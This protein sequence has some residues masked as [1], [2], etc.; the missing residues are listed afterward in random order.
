MGIRRKRGISSSCTCKGRLNWALR[1]CHLPLPSF[2]QLWPP[3]SFPQ[4]DEDE[5]FSLLLFVP[6]LAFLQ[7]M[8]VKFYDNEEK[9]EKRGEVRILQWSICLQEEETS[10]MAASRKDLLFQERVRICKKEKEVSEIPFRL[11]L[12]LVVLSDVGNDS[13]ARS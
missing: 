12:I 9:R 1:I 5:V 2:L 10:K 11:N 8:L 3:L 4:D 7:L 6:L 13:F